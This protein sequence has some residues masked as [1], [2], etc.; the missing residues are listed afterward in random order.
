[1]TKLLI[2]GAGGF[3]GAVLRYG[4]SGWVQR[5]TTST[6]PYG[7]LAVNILGSFLL[8]VVL[9]LVQERGVLP[10]AWR[11]AVAIGMLGALTTFSTFSYETME[12]LRS[13]E[14]P[15]AVLNIFVNV[16]LCLL[17]VWVGRLLLVK[18]GV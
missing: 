12:L 9:Y 4:I 18:A 2:I 13:H 16:L 7:T 6:F 5:S 1:L 11:S 3:V 14:V 15:A 8:G 10:P 17:A